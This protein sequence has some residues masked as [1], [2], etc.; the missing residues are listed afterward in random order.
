MDRSDLDRLREWF[1]AYCRSFP[2]PASGSGGDPR[3]YRVKEE[4]TRRVC[5]NSIQVAGSLGL[6][7]A[8]TALAEAIALFHDLGRFQQYRDYG[9]FRDSVSVNHAA[10]SA[11]V[12]VERGV[13]AA[14]PEAQQRLITHA[15]A[16]HNVLTVPEGLDEEMLL[17]TRLIRDADKLDIWRF[18]IEHYRLPE[19]ERPD[20]VVLG[21]PNTAGYTPGILEC[22]RRG[23]MVR[24]DMILS[25][26]DFTLLRLSWVYD[27]NFPGSFRIMD[28]RKYLSGLI[29]TLPQDD[30]LRKTVDRVAEYIDRKKG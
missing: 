22:L 18:F 17:H 6:A 27:L 14:L 15:V 20:A 3:P 19:S 7:P 8:Q 16:L 28:E 25:Q 21:L 5:E 13:L 11:S 24:H 2:G 30:A 10:L 4:H 12:L 23:Q 26:N 9:T 1:S 29:A